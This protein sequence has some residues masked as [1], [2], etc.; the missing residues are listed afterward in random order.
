MIMRNR[1]MLKMG[2]VFSV[3]LSLIIS[4]NA[5]ALSFLRK[6][7]ASSEPGQ[8]EIISEYKGKTDVVVYKDRINLWDACTGRNGSSVT[9]S[10]DFQCHTYGGKGDWGVNNV[11]GNHASIG[12]KKNSS[13]MATAEGVDVR[14]ENDVSGNIHITFANAAEKYDGSEK[15][16]I[17]VHISGVKAMVGDATGWNSGA[18]SVAIMYGYEGGG[19]NFSGFSYR[20]YFH[21]Y[22]GVKMNVEVRLRK[23]GQTTNVDKLLLWAF[24]DI[25]IKEILCGTACT[26]QFYSSSHTYAEHVT[27]KGGL[28]DSRVSVVEDD[29]KGNHISVLDYDS[30]GAI[31]HKSGTEQYDPDTGDIRNNHAD[32][33]ALVKGDS[34]NFEWGGSNCGTEIV[35]TPAAVFSDNT[36][37][38]YNGSAISNNAEQVVH[39]PTSGSL[40]FKH[41]LKRE[42]IGPP[43]AK[44][45][46][47]VDASS[48]GTGKGSSTNKSSTGD[49]GR[50]DSKKIHTNTISGLNLSPDE[51]KVLWQTIHFNRTTLNNSMVVTPN[52]SECTISGYAENGR[53]C[54]KLYRPY[55]NFEG[56]ISAVA[57]GK[58]DSGGQIEK[59]TAEI[60]SSSDKP[61]ESISIELPS[62]TGKYSVSFTQDVTR[63][64]THPEGTAGGT[65]DTAVTS[66]TDKTNYYVWKKDYERDNNSK[67]R[68][69]ALRDNKTDT[70]DHDTVWAPTYS[71]DTYG[72]LHYDES[73][74]FCN[75]L[76]VATTQSG[77][78]DQ[79]TKHICVTIHRGAKKCEIEGANQKFGVNVGHNYGSIGVTNRT[80]N[81]GAQTKILSADGAVVGI[82]T[83]VF[84]KPGDSIQFNYKMCAGAFYTAEANGIKGDSKYGSRYGAEGSLTKSDSVFKNNASNTD[85]Y[86]F[87][88]TIPMVGNTY[89]NPTRY[90]TIASLDWRWTNGANAGEPMSS[91]SFMANPWYSTAEATFTSPDITGTTYQCSHNKTSNNA[92]GSSPAQESK[93]YQ[94][95][96][97]DT[98][99]HEGIGTSVFDV[100][101]V[102]SQSLYWNNLRI[103]VSNNKNRTV[104]TNTS[105]P[106]TNNVATASVKVPYNY[107]L[108][109][110]VQNENGSDDTR[111]VYLGETYRMN[112]GVVTASR[113]NFLVTR[114]STA[115]YATITKKTHVEV[116]SFLQRNGQFVTYLGGATGNY[117]KDDVRFNRNGYLS[118]ASD[119]VKKNDSDTYGVEF[120]IPDSDAVGTNTP[121]VGDQICT[122]ITVWPADSH[123]HM[124]DDYTDDKKGGANG[125]SN[126]DTKYVNIAIREDSVDYNRRSTTSC[127][128][129][130]KRPTMSVESANAYSK[131]GYN[132]SRYTKNINVVP[133]NFSSWSEYG[134]F[135]KM[136]NIDQ[137]LISGAAV[138]Y[139]RTAP[140]NSSEKSKDR[141]NSG[142]SY[143]DVSRNGYSNICTFET[144]T[145]ANIDC[146]NKTKTSN[147]IDIG[148]RSV[149]D[150]SQKILDRYGS[151][152]VDDDKKP[153]YEGKWNNYD[154]LKLRGNLFN[155]TKNSSG[156]F[157]VK[158]ERDAYIGS[159]GIPNDLPLK[160]RVIENGELHEIDYNRTLVY[161]AAGHTVVIDGNIY[162]NNGTMNE[163]D[164]I[165]GGVIIAD[166]VYFTENVT[167]IDATII[168]KNV[169]TCKYTASGAEVKINDTGSLHTGICNQRIDFEA[170]VIVSD[171]LVLNRT[172]GADNGR[173]SI[174]RAEIFNL[175]MTNY[176]WSYNQMTRYSQAVTTYSRELP[177]RY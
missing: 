125:L 63:Y 144:Q 123:D 10:G 130:A 54:V 152:S 64:D 117:T 177:S 22:I 131:S 175:S 60:T 6:Q 85:G 98:G 87:K 69:K 105:G 140:Y 97:K 61:S 35:D 13:T 141:A 96:G 71:S 12:I 29:D 44:T 104:S 146:T 43:L 114:S 15:Y 128:Q 4:A 164:S 158:V 157:V 137:H 95:K 25:D 19:V 83:E 142:M 129:V 1:K 135:G 169:D 127:S 45:K 103:N 3:F 150:F 21:N 165:A 171:K 91:G 66:Y 82:Q 145:F 7:P 84:A 88:T 55:A 121:Q 124:T 94:V 49:M 39:S 139:Y 79:K 170:P 31:Y 41:Y 48:P 159:A 134:V 113:K 147:N 27:I 70:Y 132:M 173:D 20:K 16:D 24:N 68:T 2:I 17:Y 99:C 163:L 51:T 59:K 33:L 162:F 119:A 156:A 78:R 28:A 52:N 89:T 36:T 32:M 73:I 23:H 75:Y 72:E 102:I 133:Y 167:H 111:V 58:N 136:A 30:S 126:A 5:N 160:Y 143:S 8:L 166:N 18:N 110:Y 81:R 57:I 62:D 161:D 154:I 26:R 86:L 149:T 37:I 47:Y 80:T 14:N 108:K 174:R 40:T 176:L 38:S 56:K 118:S 92:D 50:K 120:T 74:T 53:Q 155:Y 148:G 90:Q 65:V 112:P 100:G 67:T 115:S 151:I 34:F 106:F 107:I 172:A 122:T 116:K 109:P 9:L 153:S 101:G 46:Y 11:G 168:A 42:D 138:G 93:H 77:D 76:Q